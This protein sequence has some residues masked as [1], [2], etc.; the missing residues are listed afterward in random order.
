MNHSAAKHEL[1]TFPRDEGALMTSLPQKDSA[2]RWHLHGSPPCTKVSF[3][4]NGT[5]T[6]DERRDGIDTTMWFLDVAMHKCNPT[7]FSLEQVATPWIVR[8][9]EKFRLA[10]HTT[11]TYA[12]LNFDEFGVPQLRRRVIGGTPWL[13]RRLARRSGSF[14]AV[15]T[16]QRHWIGIHNCKHPYSGAPNFA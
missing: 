9:L 7:S 2:L 8:E 6:A 16:E 4:S 11:F 5:V 12:I 1:L 14:P 15:L 10:H 3:A 13:V